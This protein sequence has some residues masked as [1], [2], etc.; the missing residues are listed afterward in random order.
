MILVIGLKFL[1]LLLMQLDL[2][3]FIY[4]ANNLKNQGMKVLGEDL[5]LF[6]N[7]ANSSIL[8]LSR[9]FC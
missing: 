3:L 6:S 4:L 5:K 1:Q 7:L 2:V 9:W 8:I